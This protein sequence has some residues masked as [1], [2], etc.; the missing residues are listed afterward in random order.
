MA[1]ETPQS[2]FKVGQVVMIAGLKKPMPFV[3]QQKRLG[4]GEWAYAWNRRNY[5][6]E[7]MLRAL[8][9]EEAG[10]G[11][12]EHVHI[13]KTISV[14]N[15]W[16]TEC[17]TCKIGAPLSLQADRHDRA[18]DRYITGNWGEDQFR[19]GCECELPETGV[20]EPSQVPNWTCPTC[21]TIWQYQDDGE[22]ESIGQ[23]ET[24]EVSDWPDDG[25]PASPERTEE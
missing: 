11:P 24:A 10:E 23:V 25:I 6:A 20:T 14:Q 18:M 15:G 5:A 17:E 19:G 7:H 1:E 16:F 22:W 8:T 3:I 12:T 4:M 13:W 21:G 2:K 9:P